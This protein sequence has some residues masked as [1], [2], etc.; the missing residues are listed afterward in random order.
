M[1]VILLY[2]FAA[3]QQT[4]IFRRQKSG[5][6]YSKLSVE[7]IYLLKRTGSDLKI[8][9]TRECL[10]NIDI[11]LSRSRSYNVFKICCAV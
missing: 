4:K 6:S 7:Y 1:S 10:K 8:A 3:Q 2:W 5:S 9:K 11:R